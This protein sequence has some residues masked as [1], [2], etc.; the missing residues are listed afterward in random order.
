[1]VYVSEDIPTKVL[2]SF[3]MSNGIESIFIEINFRNRKWLI[4]GTYNPHKHLA[5]SHLEK[6]GYTLDL[7]LAKYDN[8]LIM[9]DFSSE[10]I[11]PA[12][13]EFCDT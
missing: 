1:M 5:P 8:L 9:G 4:C 13:R 6:I 12:M 3:P 7:P 10:A 11:E 2:L